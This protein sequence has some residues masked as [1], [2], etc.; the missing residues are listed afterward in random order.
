MD[1]NSMRWLGRPYS[2]YGLAAQQSVYTSVCYGNDASVVKACLTPGASLRAWDDQRKVSRCQMMPR[3]GAGNPARV[4][5]LIGDSHAAGY[6]PAL[7][8]G[9]RDE[10]TVLYSTQGW[11]GG[12]NPIWPCNESFGE[13]MSRTELNL[14]GAAHGFGFASVELELEALSENVRPGDVVAVLTSEWRLMRREY[15]DAQREFL[16]GFGVKVGRLGASM[17]LIADN[18][19]N[20]WARYPLG[21]PRMEAVWYDWQLHEYVDAAYSSLAAEASHIFY[22]NDTFD[23]L[24]NAATGNCTPLVPGTGMPAYHDDDSHLTALGAL[25]L[26]PSVN[27]FFRQHGFI[28]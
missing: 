1:V 19:R 23:R 11:M 24:C 3:R 26:A 28:V 7:M 5:F 20:E 10:F 12:F 6:A 22:L 15:V 13:P 4:I 8:S 9:L 21:V 17:V 18:P 14:H 25:Y 27:C 2:P 16:R